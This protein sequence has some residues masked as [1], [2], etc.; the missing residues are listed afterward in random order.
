[1]TRISRRN[2][3]RTAVGAGM[4]TVTLPPAVLVGSAH[5]EQDS[6]HAAKEAGKSAGL[7]RILAELALN[8]AADDIPTK[9]YVAAKKMVLDTIGVTIAGYNAGGIAEV[10]AQ[11]RDWGGKPEATLLIHGGKLPAP[12]AAF[13]NSAMAHACDYDEQHKFG[14]AH[15]MVSV[16]P[17]CLA[18][19]EMTGATGKD[20]LAAVILGHE[21]TNRLAMAFQKQKARGGYYV[22]G[23]LPPSVIGGFGTTAAV[24]RMFGM[25]VDQ[26]VH[27]LGINYAQASGNR[28]ALF[29]KT[30]AVAKFI[31]DSL[32]LL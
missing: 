21:V 1:M 30:A 6:G 22:S 29:D 7:T 9:A 8:A 17:A 3:L 5:A 27:A 19:G 32:V 13:A 26:T 12:Q 20:L 24:C 18:A 23:F 31:R 16:L 25:T 28:Q 14:T 11:M 15:G 10:I 2:M 4:A